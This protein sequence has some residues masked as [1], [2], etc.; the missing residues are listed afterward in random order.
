MCF[1]VKTHRTGFKYDDV[2][3]KSQCSNAVEGFQYVTTALLYC[4]STGVSSGWRLK[5]L[6]APRMLSPWLHLPE[7]CL[8]LHRQRRISAGEGKCRVSPPLR[9]RGMVFMKTEHQHL[10]VVGQSAASKAVAAQKTYHTEAS[11]KFGAITGARCEGNSRNGNDGVTYAMATGE[12][13]SLLLDHC[14]YFI[15]QSKH[16]ASGR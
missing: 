4:T 8:P 13:K 16:R 9:P 11:L 6:Y 12:Q 10:L 2:P 7:R 3:G 15:T 5:P 14:A 1:S